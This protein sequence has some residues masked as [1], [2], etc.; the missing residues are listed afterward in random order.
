MAGRRVLAYV[1]FILIFKLLSTKQANEMETIP[2]GQQLNNRYSLVSASNSSKSG[3]IKPNRLSSSKSHYFGTWSL[4]NPYRKLVNNTVNDSWG[5]VNVDI[6]GKFKTVSSGREVIVLGCHLQADGSHVI[7]TLLDSGNLILRE[8]SCNG[9]TRTGNEVFKKTS[10]FFDLSVLQ[11][12]V[13]A[14]PNMNRKDCEAMCWFH[15][16]CSLY[17]EQNGSGCAYWVGKLEFLVINISGGIFYVLTSNHSSKDSNNSSNSTS[18]EENA[19][20]EKLSSLE[21]GTLFKPSHEFDKLEGGDKLGDLYSFSYESIS[22]ATDN[23]SPE[24][25]LGEGGFGPVFK[26]SLCISSKSYHLLK[27]MST[28]CV[29]YQ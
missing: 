3:F 26:V 4:K 18:E 28:N 15:C 5:V 24:N 19:S 16:G 17:T 10:G 7:V 11:V 6:N 29:G 12:H 9:S 1:L 22:A 21:M 20:K 23:F 25:K 27:E 14:D 8:V 13:Y 2:Q